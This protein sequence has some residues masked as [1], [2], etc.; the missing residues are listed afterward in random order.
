M[1]RDNLNHLLAS[2]RSVLKFGGLAGTMSL[3]GGLGIASGLPRRAG[4]A[5]SGTELGRENADD[6]TP[7]KANGGQ[8]AGFHRF[9]I[10]E[11]K[12]IALNDGGGKLSPV[13]PTFAPSA[14]AE[15]VKAV[16]EKAIVPTDH[17][18]MYFN[19]LVLSIGAE[20]ILIDT[21]NGGADGGVAGNLAAA[22]IKP[23][24]ITGIIIS[25]AHPD[26]VFGLVGAD[27]K[28]K[29]PNAKIFMNK[30]E[31]DFWTADTLNFGDL[32]VGEDSKRAWSKRIPEILKINKAAVQLV[33]GG[34]KVLGGLELVHTPGHTPGHTSVL[35]RSGQESLMAMGDLAHNYVLMFARPDWTIGFDLDRKQAVHT[36]RETFDRLAADRTRVFGYHL[37]WPA[38]GH[39]RRTGAEAFEWA[40]EPWGW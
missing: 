16:L 10:G 13:H 21:G 17:V 2:R 8:G 23:E 19:V 26:H 12:A 37:P 7:I 15:E 30:L 31:H 34:D 32:S 36:R 14:S 11:I 22:G 3:V 18:K 1:T 9:N 4:A 35:V 38:L 5:P 20:T 24:S 25:H 6:T 29:F 40:M 28:P 27:D 39:V 33:A